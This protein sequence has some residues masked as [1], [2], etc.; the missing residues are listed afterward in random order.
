MI[1][2]SFRND[3]AGM[4]KLAKDKRGT[5]FISGSTI[6]KE[7]IENG[8]SKEKLRKSSENGYKVREDKVEGKPLLVIEI[9]KD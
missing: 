4:L 1:G 7:I 5:G 8:I 2:F 3:T 6:F 9:T